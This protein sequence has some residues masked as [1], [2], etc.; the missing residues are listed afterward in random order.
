[1][2]AWLKNR[3]MLLLA[4]KQNIISVPRIHLVALTQRY[5]SRKEKLFPSAH[6]TLL[7]AVIKGGL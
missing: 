3:N 4:L 6:C 2:M 7:R 5:E 1:M